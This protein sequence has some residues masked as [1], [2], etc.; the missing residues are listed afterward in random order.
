MHGRTK[1]ICATI[2]TTIKTIHRS[3]CFKYF[4]ARKFLSAEWGAD[5]DQYLDNKHGQTGQERAF[6][7]IGR[8]IHIVSRILAGPS[9][10]CF[11]EQLP[12]LCP[13]GS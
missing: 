11:P 5:L 9:G 2:I 4:V 7:P 3:T 10:I 13:G 12:P 1:L 6:Q 8:G